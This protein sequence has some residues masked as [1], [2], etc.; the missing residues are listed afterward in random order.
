MNG[1]DQDTLEAAVTTCHNPSGKI[2]DCPVF[3]LQTI[4]E[5]A[6]C[7][8]DLP[9]ELDEDVIGPIPHLPGK[10]YIGGP[11]GLDG[12][13]IAAVA[14]EHPSISR[15]VVPQPSSTVADES[16]AP[17]AGDS[18]LVLEQS[19]SHTTEPFN[20]TSMKFSEQPP[21]TK[22]PSSS[23]DG[24]SYSVVSTEYR[25]EG[26][27]VYEIVWEEAWVYVTE[28]VTSTTTIGIDN[29]HLRRGKRGNGH[30]YRRHGHN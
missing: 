12:P 7:K 20:S 25:T 2:D 21:T 1:W 5:A 23:K 14:P 27:M 30:G 8:I 3:E 28:D 16:V 6:Q 11:D 29:N 15:D 19:A 22:P 13:A 18:S 24:V 10:N 9:E 26:N 17:I 4:E